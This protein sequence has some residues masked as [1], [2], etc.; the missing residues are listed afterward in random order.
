M[1]DEIQSRQIEIYT[2]IN[3]PIEELREVIYPESKD[4]KIAY[5]KCP[6]CGT[7]ISEDEIECSECGLR[8]K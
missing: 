2:R 6:A 7:K 8:L 5:E 3:K 1:N 4:T